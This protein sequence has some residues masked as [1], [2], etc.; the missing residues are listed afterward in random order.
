M[1]HVEGVM[2]R[3]LEA[4]FDRLWPICRSITGN[5]LRESFKILQEI[6]PLQLTEVPSGTEVFDWTIPPEW[7]IRDAYI[8]T[9]DGRKTADFKANNLHVVNYSIPV[10]QEMSMEELKPHLYSLEDQPDVV[11]YVTSYYK[12]NWGFCVPHKELV[13]LPD[14]GTYRVFIDAEKK[15][16]SLTYGHLLLPGETEDEILFSSYLCHPSMANNELSGPLALAFLY[17]ELA[18]F[19]KRRFTYRFVLA[20]ETIGVIAYLAHHGERMK[21]NIR[22][23]IVLTCCGDQ[24]KIHY[25]KSKIGHSLMDRVVEN[26]LQY[27][28]SAYAIRPFMVGG[29]DER[30]YCSPGFNFPVGS[31]MR[32]PYKEYRE[33]HTSA[34]NKS[35][36][37]FTALKETVE[38]CVKIV[39]A[40]EICRPYTG[41]VQ[42]CEP[43]LGKRGLYPSS[44]A[45]LQGRDQ[46][47]FLLRTLYFLAHADGETNLLD[48]ANAY[49]GS[50]LTFEEV[51]K[52]CYRNGLLRR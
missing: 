21:K 41:S 31:V 33:Y 40:M 8:V 19:P 48:V 3:E 14:E 27:S 42:H 9:P 15:P 28:E 18:K 29:S 47:G 39:R 44:G 20:P 43:Q 30:Q 6:I 38:F 10:D 36:I 23:G 46:Q 7:N 1:A 12:D 22:G 13:T 45:W 26:I 37:S 5:G 4:Y 51:V 32:T 34:D 16:G 2:E 25:K 50:L 49:G 24:G 11:P 17:R 52:A 35:F